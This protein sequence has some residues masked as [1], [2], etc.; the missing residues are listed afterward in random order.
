[1][2][3]NGSTSPKVFKGWKVELPARAEQTLTK[4]HSLRPVTTRTLYAGTHRIEVQINGEVCAD[5]SFE[6]EV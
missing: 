5:A 3:A 2:R 4:R 6:L 1:M